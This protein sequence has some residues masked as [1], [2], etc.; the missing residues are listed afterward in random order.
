[1]Y[2]TLSAGPDCGRACIA[3]NF[4]TGALIA[5]LGFVWGEYWMLQTHRLRLG[6]LES[7]PANVWRS[8][9]PFSA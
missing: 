3:R 9:L 8:D 2:P 1:M 6:H 7:T 4:T 5:L